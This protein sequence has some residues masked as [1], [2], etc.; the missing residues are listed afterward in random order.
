MDLATLKKLNPSEFGQ[1]ADG[2][3]ATGDMASAAKD[4]IDKVII[5]GMNKALQGKAL[6]AAIGELKKLS[7][8][9]H[10]AQ[11][12]CGLV[13]AALNGFAHDVE[14][15]R[16]KLL[17]ALDD[18]EARKF[19]VNADG[20][21]T[22]PE[23]PSTNGAEPP[24][25]GGSVSGATDPTAQAVGRQ[26]ANFDP[27]PHHAEALAIADRIAAALKEATEADSKW[28][29]KI[30]ALEAD[31]DLTVSSHDWADAKSDMDGVSKAAEDYLDS[32]K[33][34]PKDG[35]PKANALWWTEL[36]PEE[37]ADYL[38]LHPKTVGAMNGLPAE[39]RDEANRIVFDETRGEYQMELDSLP[40]EPA[41]KYTLI[42]TINGPVRVYS[43]EWIAWN[44]K[45]GDRTA[46]LEK[47]LRGTQ[48][49]QERFDRT[50]EKGLPEAYLLGFDP[51]GEGD[52]RVILANGNP[53]MA[54]HTAVFVPGTG[55]D[56]AGT[57]GNIERS[58]AMWRESQHLVPGE[59][60][61]SIYWFDY[62]AP[63]DIPQAMGGSRAESAG[64]RL[65]G[66]LE[67]TQ[68]AQGGPNSSHTTVIGHSYGSTVIGETARRDD[69]P[70]DD[71]IALGSP[72]MQVGH[73]KDLGV[74]ADHVWA[75]GADGSV[76]DAVVR[77]GG[78][79]VGLGDWWANPT[80]EDFGA[81]VMQNDTGSLLS[82]H[83]SYWDYSEGQASTSL[84][85]QASVIA[86]RYG[87]V[88]L[89]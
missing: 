19:T 72:G 20:S 8:N 18:A 89:E 61:S 41:N 49:I 75:E 34:P 47:V 46:E 77:H 37:R 26:S 21:V 45:Y 35:D 39:T 55:T 76:D 10:Y 81:N 65:G 80:D 85:N 2:Y 84:Q 56:I 17:A 70:V 13:S 1:A 87:D 3:R 86:G 43:D 66:F 44:G 33:H 50:G 63:N 16:K 11:T 27:N 28:E 14:A 73:A 64:P 24:P 71:I 4:E 62:D 5:A 40:A 83:S 42:N 68:V 6:E 7:A 30:R 88:K 74:G 22:Y 82:G 12:E 25:K 23:G 15:A 9:F 58:E 54:E 79:I 32:I 69:I 78:R 31:D 29:P 48:A 53:D 36:T 38:A 60:V 52:G 67:G 59:S 57:G 51:K